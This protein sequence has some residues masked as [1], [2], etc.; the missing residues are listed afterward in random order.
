VPEITVEI[1]L[2]LNKL[3][4]SPLTLLA[5]RYQLY[6]Q[7]ERKKTIFFIAIFVTLISCERKINDLSLKKCND[8]NFFPNLIDQLA[9]IA[10]FKILLLE[11]Q[12]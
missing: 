1:L 7:N 2:S 9:L 12:F 10:E 11:N 4:K 8:R 5:E 3:L 6:Y